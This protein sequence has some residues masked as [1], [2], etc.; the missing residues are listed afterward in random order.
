[1]EMIAS[2]ALRVSS[3]TPITIVFSEEMIPASLL[4]TISPFVGGTWTP[5][6]IAGNTTVML[7]HTELF[8]S[9]TE[10]TVTVMD[11]RDLDN[12]VLIPGAPNPWIFR[13]TV[14][15]PYVI[16]T[17]PQDG[18]TGVSI[19]ATVYVNFSTSMDT[20]TV[21]WALTPPDVIFSSS[22]MNNNVTLILTPLSLLS[23]LTLYEINITGGMDESGN[24]LVRDKGAPNPWTF[25]TG[26]VPPYIVST[27]PANDTSGVPVGQPIEVVFSEEMDQISVAWTINPGIML[28]PSWSAGNTTV[29][30]THADL[31]TCQQYQVEITSALDMQGLSLVPGPVPNPW[32][33]TTE[34]PVDVGPPTGLQ[35]IRT[36]PDTVTVTWNPV[37]NATS[38]LVYDTQNRFDPFPWVSVVSVPVPQTSYDFVGHLDDG[39]TH[40]YIVTAY[41]SSSMIAGANSTM[42]VKIHKD[43]SYDPSASNIYWMSLPYNSIYIKASDIVAELTSSNIVALGKWDRTAQKVLVYYHIRGRWRGNDFNIQPGDGFYVGTISTFSWY[44]TGT[45]RSMGLSLPYSMNKMNEHWISVPYTGIYSMASDIVI[46]IEGHTGPGS[47][48]DIIEIGRWDPVTHTIMIYQYTPTGWTGD[49]NIYPGDGIYIKVVN[50]FT[51]TPELITPEV[52]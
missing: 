16:D 26:V 20:A 13:T 4:W 11:C 28:I 14:G 22:W 36:F 30:F 49:F 38:Y 41:N 18:D 12:N 2:S 43:F 34:C 45:D 37:Q 10:Y 24:P 25:T 19:S 48:Q 44:I 15:N 47:N 6:W 29:T 50:T 17:N 27:D 21:Q 5:D 32:W 33:F 31:M 7:N 3:F 39:L 35:V 40:Y 23:E 42:G 52:P 46:D 51:W 1:L 8:Q 9:D